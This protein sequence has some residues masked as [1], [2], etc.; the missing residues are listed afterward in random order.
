MRAWRYA[1]ARRGTNFRVHVS[2][3]ARSERKEKRAIGFPRASERIGARPN[4]IAGHPDPLP[5]MG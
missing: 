3:P 2:A 1:T 5:Y 4:P